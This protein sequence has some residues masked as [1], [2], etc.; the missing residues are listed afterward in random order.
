MSPSDER[1]DAD[2]VAVGVRDVHGVAAATSDRLPMLDA[3]TVEPLQGQ[4]EIAAGAHSEAHRIEP[5]ERGRT[6]GVFPQRKAEPA[7][8][9]TQPYAA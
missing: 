4:V 3:L 2:E 1:V 9:V 5:G 8:D 7:S 6:R